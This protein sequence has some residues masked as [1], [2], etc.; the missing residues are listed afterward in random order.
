MESDESGSSKRNKREAMERV[1]EREREGIARRGGVGVGGR[2]IMNPVSRRRG[3]T[4]QFCRFLRFG[5]IYCLHLHGR[6]CRHQTSPTIGKTVECSQYISIV[7]EMGLTCSEH[8]MTITMKSLL[9]YLKAECTS[10]P[11]IVHFTGYGGSHHPCCSWML[12]KSMNI[13]KIVSRYKPQKKYECY[14]FE[15]ELSFWRKEPLER[16]RR[17]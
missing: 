2:K 5:R 7:N 17:R 1:R 3:H 4:V 11:F 13:L 12:R 6:T 15:C 14:Q 16:P 10:V 9:K 8:G